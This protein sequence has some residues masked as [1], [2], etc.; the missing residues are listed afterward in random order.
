MLR[1][2]ESLHG[3]GLVHLLATLRNLEVLVLDCSP[4]HTDAVCALQD[5]IVNRR[6]LERRSRPLLLSMEGIEF[7]AKH[8]WL[9]GCVKRHGPR[10]PGVIVWHALNAASRLAGRAACDR[11][12]VVTMC[13][14]KA[15]TSN[16]PKLWM[17]YPSVAATDSVMKLARRATRDVCHIAR[18]YGC[19]A[20]LTSAC[21]ANGTSH[22]IAD[23]LFMDVLVANV[24]HLMFEHAIVGI[25]VYK[26][27]TPTG[28]AV[29]HGVGRLRHLMLGPVEEGTQ[30]CILVRIACRKQRQA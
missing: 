11:H 30:L 18:T 4:I 7:A 10:T 20:P 22:L 15:Q 8:A 3:R 29:R 13:I 23:E 21:R 9:L 27:H 14:C 12:E 24:G 26:V 1:G 28:V 16:V 5:A 6:L 2:C 25:R 17:W 19:G